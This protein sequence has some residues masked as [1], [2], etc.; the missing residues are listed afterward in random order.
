MPGSNWKRRPHWTLGG[1]AAPGTRTPGAYASAFFNENL[2]SVSP[3]Q[4]IS[5]G[6]SRRCLRDKRRAPFRAPRPYRD[7]MLYFVERWCKRSGAMGR[8][9]FVEGAMPTDPQQ[10]A[11]GYEPSFSP[12]SVDSGHS[13]K[14]DS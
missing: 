11:E 10:E 9:Q 6:N 1:N 5:Q 14:G 12:I 2:R 3:L 13:T 7:S 8:I 4:V